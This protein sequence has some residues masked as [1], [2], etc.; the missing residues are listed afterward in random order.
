MIGHQKSP[1]QYYQPGLFA[2][3]GSKK[4]EPSSNVC[5]KANASS[6]GLS[7]AYE[8]LGVEARIENCAV[9]YRLQTQ[10]NCRVDVS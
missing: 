1:D 4:F 3:E 6:L 10:T 2:L 8:S 5:G 9:R 7:R